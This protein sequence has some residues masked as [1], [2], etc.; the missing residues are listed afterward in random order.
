MASPF[1]QTEAKKRQRMPKGEKYHFIDDCGF[2]GT[3]EDNRELQDDLRY[4]V[5]NY[6]PFGEE[7]EAESAVNKIKFILLETEAVADLRKQFE[8]KAEKFTVEALAHFAQHNPT[9]TPYQWADKLKDSCVAIAE[10]GYKEAVKAAKEWME[11]YFPD[12]LDGKGFEFVSR[13]TILA[14]FET[15]MFKNHTL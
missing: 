11:N 10:F 4:K 14:D 9:P 3:K 7:E 8:S 1:N 2:V 13:D 15:D 12:E 6:F 5:G